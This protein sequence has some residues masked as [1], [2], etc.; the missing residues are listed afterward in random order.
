MKTLF[1]SCHSNK[2]VLPVV[3]KSL[4]KLEGLER[5]GIV[6]T[7]Q[8]LNRIGAVEGFL[9]KNKKKPVAGG[10]IL[11]CNPAPASKIEAVVDAFLYI[12]SGMFHPLALAALTDKPIIIANP[13]SGDVLEISDKDRTGIVKRQKARIARAA[14]ACV[15]GIL[16][17]TKTGQQN[18]SY[19]LNLKKK[20]EET[21]KKAFIFAGVELIPDRLLGYRVD[22]YVNTA[23]PRILDDF[24]DKPVIGPDELGV[25]L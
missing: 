21:G 6:T 15:F 25:I 5:I 8:H 14:Q 10:Q 3:R 13:Y 1:I 18:F 4:K 19:A 22:A 12:G 23:C 17:S 7:A 16:V 24:F 9:I 20:I 11:G 2:D